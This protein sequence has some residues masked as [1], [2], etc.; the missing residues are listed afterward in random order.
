MKSVEWESGKVNNDTAAATCD[1]AT[2]KENKDIN[3]CSG[4]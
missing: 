4:E 3:I 2:A 1:E